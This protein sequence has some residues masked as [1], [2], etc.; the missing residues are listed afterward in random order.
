MRCIFCTAAFCILCNVAEFA[1]KWLYWQTPTLSHN[2]KN[3][4]CHNLHVAPWGN[5]VEGIIFGSIWMAVHFVFTDEHTVLLTNIIMFGVSEGFVNIIVRHCWMGETF[6]PDPGTAAGPAGK[7][8][9]SRSGSGIQYWFSR[10][11]YGIGG[12]D[13]LYWHVCSAPVVQ[14]R[15]SKVLESTVPLVLFGREPLHR[16]NLGTH[17]LIL[18]IFVWVLQALGSLFWTECIIKETD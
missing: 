16:N 7:D 14:F 11:T 1:S 2:L 17:F 12:N 4:F 9:L 13:I 15:K 18:F 3:T 6:W 5:F 10:W 8:S